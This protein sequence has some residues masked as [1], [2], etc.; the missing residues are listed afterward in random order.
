ML[1]RLQGCCCLLLLTI[2]TGSSAMCNIQ[3]QGVVGLNF[4]SAGNN[5]QI[6]LFIINSTDTTAGFT[7]TFEFTNGGKFKSGVNEIPM[8][9]LSLHKVSGTLGAGLTEPVP[10]LDILHNLSGNQY[11]W[12]PGALQTTNTVNFIVE[13]KA[14]WS[15]PAGKLAGFYFEIITVT[16]SGCI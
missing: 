8:T 5:S 3:S 14:S 16:M 11:T 2:A 13:L 10:P 1:H 7:V 12:T 6:A 4:A 15:N 9:S